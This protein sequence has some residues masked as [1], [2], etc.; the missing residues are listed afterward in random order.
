MGGAIVTE[1]VG[2]ACRAGAPAPGVFTEVSDQLGLDFEHLAQAPPSRE[3]PDGRLLDYAGVGLADLDGDGALDL[4]FTNAGGPDRMYVTG[5]RGPAAFQPVDL[6]VEPWSSHGVVLG[7][8]DGD[9]DVDAVVSTDTDPYVL[10]ND[11]TGRLTRSVILNTA[12]SESD[13][14]YGIYSLALGDL[15]GDGWLD[16]Y[17][18]VHEEQGDFDPIARPGSEWWMR[19]D[20]HGTFVDRSDRIPVRRVDDKTFL[21]CVLDLDDDGDLDIYEVNDVTSLAILGIDPSDSEPQGNRLYRNDGLDA[22]GKL[23]LVDIS[24]ESGAGIT[25]S[26]M[27]AAV[28]DY[29]NDG[30]MDFYVTSMLP[31]PNFLLHN[32]GDMRF[33]DRTAESGSMTLGPTHDVAWGAVFFDADMDGW[34]DLFVTHGWNIQAR[35]SG[36]SAQ[37]AP[38]Q[39]GSGAPFR[40]RVGGRG[41]GRSGLEPVARGG[42]HR[43]RW[44]SR[45][46]GGERPGPALRVPEWL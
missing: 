1:T 25:T 5:G 16:I 2:A 26:G 3:Q 8:I 28:G 45:S 36:P 14:T 24:E 39:P 21:V 23:T 34:P 19:S 7:D 4:F 35:E 6:D 13:E 32:D 17:V 46:G 43:S 30:R 44:L 29:D 20:R 42:G 11:G 27:G 12:L 10:Y 38:A 37:R 40:G 15:D 9:G 41:F 18:G 33:S 31:D 22:E